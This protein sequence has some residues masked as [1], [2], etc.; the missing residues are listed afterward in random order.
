MKYV[1]FVLAAV[2]AGCAQPKLLAS[3][4]RSVAV[5]G[6]EDDW[7]RVQPVA[8]EACAKHGLKARFK[9]NTRDFPSTYF[10]DCIN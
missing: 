10:Y 6:G 5:R 7:A 2:L 9:Y 4:D 8:E 1:L 3:N